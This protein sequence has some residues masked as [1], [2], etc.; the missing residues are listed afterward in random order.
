LH[1]ITTPSCVYVID[2]WTRHHGQSGSSKLLAISGGVR[3][4][5]GSLTTPSRLK[6]EQT[7]TSPPSIHCNRSCCETKSR[8]INVFWLH[9][10]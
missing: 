8:V 3:H 4:A 1:V 7:H 6:C 2:S 9:V 5:N 10:G